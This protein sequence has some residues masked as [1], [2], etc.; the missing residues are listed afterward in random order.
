MSSLLPYNATKLEKTLEEAIKYDIDTHVLSGFKFKTAGD[1]I[2][3]ALSWEYSLSQINIDDFRTRVIEGLKFHRL[4]GT[5]YSL[6]QAFS[7][8]GFQNVSI[9][10]EVP[11]E[12]FSEFQVG[13]QEIPNNLDVEKIIEV[14]QLAAPLRS[15]L[16]RM[17]ND[18]YD[19]RRFVLDESE[20]GDLLS[21]HSG[22]ELYEG[23]PKF[24]FGRVNNFEATINPPVFKSYTLRMHYAFAENIDTYKLDWTILDE[25][26]MGT[27]NHD[28]SRH[29]YRFM[30]NTNSV[31][32]N[33]SDIFKSRK[34][35]RA[36]PVLSEDAVLG[37]INTCFSCGYETVDVE[38]F[39]LSQSYLSA[40]PVIRNQVLVACREFRSS[41]FFGTNEPNYNAIRGYKT[42][43]TCITYQH[44][45]TIQS[46]GL[47]YR[48]SLASY[49][50]NNSWLDQVYLDIPWNE[51]KNWLGKIK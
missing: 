17:Y 7:W 11:G 46:Y 24:S 41:S 50:G 38:P 9:E 6:K 23:S 5:P 3:L 39:I 37:D 44:N 26:D 29:V 43:I 42:N 27:L 10:E 45:Y 51:Q 30:F 18:L 14:S 22:N 15:R 1:N 35:A 21:D 19:V 2:N 12:H 47:K 25:T 40:Q 13:V 36:L 48:F 34:I 16:S 4:Q 32:E 33:I 28:M 20:W 8:Y 31:C 49:Q